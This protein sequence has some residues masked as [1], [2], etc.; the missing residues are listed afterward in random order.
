MLTQVD[1]CSDRFTMVIVT[2]A[3]KIGSRV[4][5][6]IA[7]TTGAMVSTTKIFDLAITFV[8]NSMED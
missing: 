4:I 3:G 2:D 6:H 7:A 1:I 8:D 5:H